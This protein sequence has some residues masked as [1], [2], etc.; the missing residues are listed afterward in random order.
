MNKFNSFLLIVLLLWAIS[1]CSILS[2]DNDSAGEIT[3][4][5]ELSNLYYANG[6]EILLFKEE[7]IPFAL[8]WK[9][10]LRVLQNAMIMAGIIK[11]KLM[12]I[13]KSRILLLRMSSALTRITV[14]NS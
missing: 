7:L 8:M 2:E 13:L 9:E 11:Q 14:R 4:P 3:K 12:E 1:S 6:N 5:W 10:N